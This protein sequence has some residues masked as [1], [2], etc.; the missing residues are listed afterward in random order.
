MRLKIEVSPDERAE[1]IREE[2]AGVQAKIAETTGIVALVE[3][4]GR[5]EKSAQTALEKTRKIFDE[6]GKALQEAGHNLE[7]AGRDHERLSKD[8]AASGRGD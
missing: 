5:Q 7:T 4:K 8:C 2:I 6:S 3:E 1:K